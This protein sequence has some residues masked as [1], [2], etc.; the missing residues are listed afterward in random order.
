MSVKNLG[1]YALKGS[2]PWNIGANTIVDILKGY[3]LE[4]SATLGKAANR[5]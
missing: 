1:R 5:L 2:V 4:A 3:G